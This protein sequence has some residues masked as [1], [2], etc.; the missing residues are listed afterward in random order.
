VFNNA[1]HDFLANDVVANTTSEF[2]NT[3]D[4]FETDFGPGNWFRDTDEGLSHLDTDIALALETPD[5]DVFPNFHKYTEEFAGSNFVFL[6]AFFPALEKMSML[7]VKKSDLHSP[8]PCDACAPVVITPLQILR[9]IKALGNA[10]ATAD[11][12]QRKRQEEREEVID[13]I[14]TPFIVANDDIFSNINIVKTIKAN[15]GLTSVPSSTPSTS[16]PSITPSAGP[17]AR[18]L[19]VFRP[20]TKPTVAPSSNPSGVPSSAPSVL[21]KEEERARGASS[22]LN[23]MEGDDRP[24]HLITL[25]L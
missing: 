2:N 25:G 15:D 5:K 19:I 13:N 6:D 1:Y 10:T 12:V 16:A 7:G 14:T 18:P 11:S 3:M 23:L 8:G 9:A 4:P 21:T 22:Y 20:G 24:V 17:S